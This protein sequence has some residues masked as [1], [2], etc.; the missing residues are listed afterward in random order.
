MNRHTRHRLAHRLIAT[1]PP[2][3]RARYEAELHALVD[4]AGVTGRTIVD[5]VAASARAW[6]TP[7]FSGSTTEASRRRLQATVAT[8]WVACCAGS[9]TVP[10]LYRLLLDPRP[11]NIDPTVQRLLVA[12][13]IPLPVTA[14]L[15]ASAGLVAGFGA[16]RA[17]LARR[18]RMVLGPVLPA[19]AL[20]LIEVVGMGVV[21]LLRRGHPAVWPHPSVAFTLVGSAWVLGFGAFV[22]AAAVGP[23]VAVTRAAPPATRLRPAAVLAA[24]AAVTLAI[25]VALCVAAVTLV[26]ASAAGL[27]GVLYGTAALAV[28]LTSAARGVRALRPP[29]STN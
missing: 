11:A 7:T 28:A 25:A 13:Q 20:G 2:C 27:I 18:D 9:I 5:L 23:A 22:I 14:V 17:A 15:V 4:D 16:G 1:Y 6:L 29:R 19:V 26:G 3:F 12:A 8:T 21:W 24:A 10:G